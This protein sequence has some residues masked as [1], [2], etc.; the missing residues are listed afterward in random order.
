MGNLKVEIRQNRR[1]AESQR[2]RIRK[3]KIIKKILCV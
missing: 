3:N 1:N 2:K